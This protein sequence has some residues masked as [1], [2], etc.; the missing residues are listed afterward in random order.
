MTALEAALRKV[1]RTWRAPAPEAGPAFLSDLKTGDRAV[2]AS[3][4]GGAGFRG[5]MISLGL[6]PGTEITLVSGGQG[7]PFVLK[8]GDARLMIGWGMA[9]KVAVTA[10]IPAQR[11]K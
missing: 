2:I 10:V 11:G 3:L 8:V 5:K 6:V 7:Q 1:K 9:Q 4:R